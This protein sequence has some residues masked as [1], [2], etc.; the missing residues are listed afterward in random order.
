MAREIKLNSNDWCDIVFEGK[1]K[2]YGA[3]ELRQTSSK[4]HLIAFGTIVV[5]VGIILALPMFLNAVNPPK[6]MDFGGIDDVWKVQNIEEQPIEEVIV[7]PIAATPPP[8]KLKASDMFTP[9]IVKPDAEVDE[10]KELQDQETLH[11]S[12]NEI[13][14]ATIE[15]S[16]DADAVSLEHNM[17]IAAPE[18]TP[19]NT[20]FVNVEVM[21]KFAGGDT[22]LMRYLSSN[23]KYPTIAVENGIEGRVVL[24]FVVRKNG[25]IEDVNVVRSLDPSCDKEAMRVV[26]SMPKWIPGMQNGQAVDVY[27]TLPVLFRLQK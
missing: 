24:K 23:I 1:N 22:E 6:K 19:Q 9:P 20:I 25:N 2:N 21:P 7:D 14:F 26:K 27:F 3:Y 18:P 16:N 5:F 4:R 13:S 15:G 8:V 10:S 17:I 12:K 11:N